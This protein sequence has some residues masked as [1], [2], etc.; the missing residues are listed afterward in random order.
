MAAI[1]TIRNS[2]I[3]IEEIRISENLKTRAREMLKIVGAG[4][5]E[6]LEDR[7]IFEDRKV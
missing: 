4:D 2:T 7:R 1:S 3:R 5:F 6:N